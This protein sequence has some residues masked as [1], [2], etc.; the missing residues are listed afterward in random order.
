MG[1]K[2]KPAHNR[3]Q[4]DE[5]Q[6]IREYQEGKS[7]L[8][9]SK[10]HDTTPAT[11]IKLLKRNGIET[12]GLSAAHQAANLANNRIKEVPT[13]SEPIELSEATRQQFFDKIPE[14][15]RLRACTIK[16][17]GLYDE[18]LELTRAYDGDFT[19]K[20]RCLQ[21]GHDNKCIECGAETTWS[22]LWRWNRYC[23]ECHPQNK[24]KN[25]DKD[26]IRAYF[27]E[28]GWDAT[29]E[30]FDINEH[31]MNRCG[32]RRIDEQD[33]IYKMIADDYKAGM[34]IA[35]CARHHNTSQAHVRS[36]LKENGVKNHTHS[37]N[38]HRAQG[39]RKTYGLCQGFAN[40]YSKEE[41]IELYKN[42]MTAIDIAKKLNTCDWTILS[43]VTDA[44]LR[45]PRDRTTEPEKKCLSLLPEGL[46]IKQHDRTILD[47]KELDIFIP[48][49][50]LAIEING[51]YW[52]ST[53]VPKTD[54]RHLE[55]FMQCKEK[56]IKLLQLTDADI[57]GRPKLIRSMLSAK[58]GLNERI[59]ARKTA[60]TEI[61]IK[62]ANKLFMEWHYQGQTTN[63]A[64][65][66]AL[67]YQHEVVALLAYRIQQDKIIIDRY[68]SK[69]DTTVVGGYSK[70]E[71]CLPNLR[72]E[73]FSLGLISDGSLYAS[74]GYHTP[75]YATSPEFYITDGARL[76]NRQ[77]FM[78]H[79]LQAKFGAGFDH[80]KTEWENVISNGLRL[81]F[82]AGITKWI[83]ESPA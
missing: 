71:S 83:K 77:H 11:I 74:S 59:Y 21:S 7:A 65:V 33:R 52:H 28:H 63:S 81:Y 76:M 43:I 32:I 82:G 39:G 26:A 19:Y 66:L 9:L 57:L 70:L 6:I 27:N 47:G 24:N 49:H 41:I 67:I 13:R 16:R 10:K 38:M 42:G 60:I 15:C 36:A 62:E 68:A 48:S 20:M 73:T 12:R 40:S 75:G 53:D 25:L 51:L 22:A 8:Q 35:E 1:Q 54:K 17:L 31:S 5:A 14:G 79:K 58:L 45:K 69:L 37:Y 46:K 34:T 4:F 55:K 29:V 64:K 72:K 44:G 80:D 56:G 61:P 18:F 30:H 3:K 23:E 2:G 78:K 50:N